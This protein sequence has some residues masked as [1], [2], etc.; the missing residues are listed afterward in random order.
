[1]LNARL[2]LPALLTSGVTEELLNPGDTRAFRRPTRQFV[3]T[4]ITTNNNDAMHYY[5]Y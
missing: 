2:E 1:V 5:Y 3:T 4:I